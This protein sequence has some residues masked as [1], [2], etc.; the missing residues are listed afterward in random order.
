MNFFVW[1]RGLR[2]PEPQ[3]HLLDPRSLL[4]WKTLE[5]SVIGIVQLKEH[6][7]DYTLAQAIA[8]YPCPVS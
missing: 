6:E 1:I 4:S 7:R 5:D 3:L 8:A 2:G